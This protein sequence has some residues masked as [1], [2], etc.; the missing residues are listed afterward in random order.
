[1]VNDFCYSL[2]LSIGH[3]LVAGDAEFLGVD[4]LSNREAKAVPVRIAGLLMWWNG[5][6][7]HGLHTT[8]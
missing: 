6:M 5:I 4:A 7:N 2:D 3:G 1:M 8:V